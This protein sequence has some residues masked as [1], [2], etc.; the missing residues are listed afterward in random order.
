MKIGQSA[1]GFLDLLR[2]D[3][4]IGIDVITA[5]K[6]RKYNVTANCFAGAPRHQVVRNNSQQRAQ[7]KN[8][9]RFLSQNCDFRSRPRNRIQFASDGFDEGRFSAAIGSEN[10]EVFPALDTQVEV[11]KHD[12]RSA[13]DL[14][15]LQFK[16]R[17]IRSRHVS[18]LLERWA[19]AYLL[20]R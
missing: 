16:Q 17:R 20:A 9:P 11:V 4:V 6:P 19:S 3:Q 5:E 1:F 12:L 2:R 15:V 18:S 10:G 7:F 8:I 14:E 13:H